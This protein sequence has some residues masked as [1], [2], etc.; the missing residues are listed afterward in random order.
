MERRDWVAE[1][2]CHCQDGDAYFTGRPHVIFIPNSSSSLSCCTHPLWVAVAFLSCCLWFI[3]E[4]EMERYSTVYSTHLTMCPSVSND[5][6][7]IEMKAVLWSNRA[8]YSRGG[9]V[10]L[11]WL[12]VNHWYIMRCNACTSAQLELDEVHCC[13]M[14]CTMGLILRLYTG[15]LASCSEKVFILFS[16]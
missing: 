15:L 16:F 6:R 13:W 2:V 1:W 7:L 12:V 3:C 11:E 5:L 4:W 10:G 9:A 8:E 14:L